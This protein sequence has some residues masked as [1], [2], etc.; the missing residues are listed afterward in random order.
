MLW[1]K[2]E[3]RSERPPSPILSLALSLPPPWLLFASPHWLEST[4]HVQQLPSQSPSDRRFSWASFCSLPPSLESTPRQPTSTSRHDSDDDNLR[5]PGSHPRP[6]TASRTFVSL[7][8]AS[9]TFCFESDQAVKLIKA[10]FSEKDLSWTTTPRETRQWILRKQKISW[11]FLKFPRFS[12]TLS[13]EEDESRETAESNS[14]LKSEQR[15]I[16]R[17]AKTNSLLEPDFRQTKTAFISF[18]VLKKDC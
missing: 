6:I 14:V 11:K 1:W 18:P 12:W 13:T 7:H 4:L 3:W 5:D 16:S 15:N 17:K 9:T 2:R 10:H 8:S